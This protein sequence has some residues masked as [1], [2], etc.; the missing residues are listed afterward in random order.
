MIWWRGSSG[1]RWGGRCWGAADVGGSG[2]IPGLRI[3]I[4]N[5]GGGGPLPILGKHNNFDDTTTTEIV[6]H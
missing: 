6:Q 3:E 2:G 1:E 5:G 4:L